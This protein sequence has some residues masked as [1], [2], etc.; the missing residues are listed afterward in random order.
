MLAKE[1]I[2]ERRKKLRR[3]PSLKK[4][5]FGYGYYGNTE[6]SSGETGDGGG[7]SS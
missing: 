2:I 6:N 4:Y 1:F 3:K 7:E 5:Y